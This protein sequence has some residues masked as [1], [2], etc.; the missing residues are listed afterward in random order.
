VSEPAAPGRLEQ[1]LSR[2]RLAPVAGVAVI[3]VL[4]WLWLAPMALDMYGSMSG[5]ARWMAASG[6]DGRYALL[7]F[8]MWVVMMV[9]MMLPSAAP[10]LLMYGPVAR[11]AGGAAS[12][13]P[14]FVLGYLAAWTG[15]SALATAAQWFLA[16]RALLS[17]MMES[18]SALLNGA[19]LMAAGAYQ[20]TAL[21]NLCLTE[22]RSPAHT[23]TRLWR[24]GPMGALRMGLR[25]GLYCVGCCWALMALLFVGGVMNLAWIVALTLFVLAEKAL[26]AGA[27]LGRLAAP[28]LLIAGAWLVATAIFSGAVPA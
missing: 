24:P 25:H 10:V 19:L 3:A 5:S 18:A 20:W 17:P 4:A 2:E 1:L 8:L 26:P 28:P 12:G 23:L 15:F 27:R 22:C 13:L 6:W 16:S 7:V 21:K 9:G 14:L 11:S